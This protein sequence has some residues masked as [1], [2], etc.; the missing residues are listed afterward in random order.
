VVVALLGCSITRNEDVC[1]VSGLGETKQA[2]WHHVGVVVHFVGHGGC[3]C[4]F[5]GCVVCFMGIVGLY[6]FAFMGVLIWGVSTFVVLL[7]SGK[8]DATGN[9]TTIEIVAASPHLPHGSPTP[10]ISM[11]LR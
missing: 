8:G 11:L 4:S 5:R 1:F 10:H 7:G 2:C 3:C 6:D 9:V